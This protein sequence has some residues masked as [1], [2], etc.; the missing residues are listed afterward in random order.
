MKF[1]AILL[2]MI[3][4][5]CLQALVFENNDYFDYI[6]YLSKRHVLDL[7]NND[8]P[9]TENGIRLSYIGSDNNDNAIYKYILKRMK[10]KKMIWFNNTLSVQGEY[11]ENLHSGIDNSLSLYMD[12]NDLFCESELITEYP[13]SDT[14]YAYQMSRKEW[15]NTSSQIRKA[16]ISYEKNDYLIAGGRFIPAMGRGIFD[17]LFIS[18]EIEPLDGFYFRFEKQFFDFSFYTATLT[19]GHKE[20]RDD[21]LRKYVSY[22]KAGVKLPYNN[23]LAFKE[24]ISYASLLPELMYTNPIL[25]Y[26]GVQWNTHRDDNVVW[27]IEAINKSIR[28]LTLSGE[29]FVDD[30]IYEKELKMLFSD[31]TL[32]APDKLGIIVS[33]SYAPDVVNGLLIEGEYARI[34]KYTGTHRHPEVAYSYYNEPVLYFIGPDADLMGVRISYY[35]SDKWGAR[36]YLSYKRKGEGRIYDSFVEST[37]QD[38]EFEFP[39]G[40]IEKTIQ[41]N[42]EIFLHYNIFTLKM[43]GGYTDIKNG[44]NIILDNSTIPYINLIG[45]INL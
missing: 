5:I 20:F 26:Y 44:N 37:N 16:Y 22:H 43:S 9:L 7:R 32:Y 8:I 17:N 24:L 1:I 18:S 3:T 28:G 25:L 21:S 45:E 27:A 15:N 42:I 12:M 40:I 10:K 11:K 23:Y 30:F 29:L 34:S 14:S 35:S 33:A 36:G 13:Y 41:G 31:F 2:L 4:A 38:Y 6:D 19:P 39:S